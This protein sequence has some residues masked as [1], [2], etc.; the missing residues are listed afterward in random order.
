MDL[1]NILINTSKTKLFCKSLKA[2]TELYVN[3]INVEETLNTLQQEIDALIPSGN[4]WVNNTDE[5]VSNQ[6][7]LFTDNSVN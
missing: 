7:L 3:N 1:K 5:A 4:P 2:S 6:Q